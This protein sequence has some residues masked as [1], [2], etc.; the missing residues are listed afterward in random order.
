MK[1]NKK[2]PMKYKIKNKA[3]DT[4]EKYVMRCLS[5]ERYTEYEL[6]IRRINL[7]NIDHELFDVWNKFINNQ[8]HMRV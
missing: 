1:K 8:I 2:F 6:W 3:S 5:E 7:K 4:I